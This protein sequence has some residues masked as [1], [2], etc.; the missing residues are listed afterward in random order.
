MQV[1]FT[2]KKET[3]PQVTING[4]VINQAQEAKYSLALG[5]ST[6]RYN[7]AQQHKYYSKLPIENVKN[8][9]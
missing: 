7:W 8:H 3:F 2:F 9:N 5:I 4:T 1:T 6:M